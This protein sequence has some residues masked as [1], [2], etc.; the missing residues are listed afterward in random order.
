MVDSLV[1]LTTKSV[2][3]AS[4]R[5]DSSGLWRLRTISLSGMFLPV[6]EQ[7]R[8]DINQPIGASHHQYNILPLD[9]LAMRDR[10]VASAAV[11]YI[12]AIR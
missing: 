1:I 4:K 6:S 5:M 9:L 8:A 11:M 10:T 12:M 2:F 7:S 3:G